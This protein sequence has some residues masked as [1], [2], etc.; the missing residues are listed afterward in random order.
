MNDEKLKA[1]GALAASG[2]AAI[3]ASS[4]CLGPLLLVSL[5]FSGAWIGNLGAMEQYRP[6]LIGVAVLALALAWRGIFRPIAACEDD[7]ICSTPRVKKAY[8]ITFWI[9]AVLVLTAVSFPYVLPF[10]Y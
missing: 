2:L 6:W 9:V 3:L 7:A 1:R 8:Q 10:F 5:G 4:C